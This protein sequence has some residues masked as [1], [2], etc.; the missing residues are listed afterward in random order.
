[1]MKNYKISSNIKLFKKIA[2]I[3]GVILFILLS[4]FLFKIIS[5]NYLGNIKF[6]WESEAKCDNSWGCKCHLNSCKCIY[7][8]DKNNRQEYIKCP[9]VI[10]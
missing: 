8:D 1:M 6:T 4:L 10:E 5:Y 7:Y 9:S 3:Q 2:I